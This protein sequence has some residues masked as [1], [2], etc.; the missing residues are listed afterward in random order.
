MT[1]ITPPDKVPVLNPLPPYSVLL[2]T[3]KTV[4]RM[5]PYRGSNRGDWAKHSA[6]VCKG[7]LTESGIPISLYKLDQLVRSAKRK[8]DDASDWAAYTDRILKGERDINLGD[9][10]GAK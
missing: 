9:D 1:K 2:E 10:K 7:I 3:F 6:R 5:Y 8:S 4:E